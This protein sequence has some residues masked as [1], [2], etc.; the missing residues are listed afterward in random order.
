ML[1]ILFSVIGVPATRVRYMYLTKSWTTRNP[2]GSI[3]DLGVRIIKHKLSYAEWNDNKQDWDYVNVPCNC[4]I[5]Q[6]TKK[7]PV[8]LSL[9]GYR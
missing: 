9:F 2:D 3:K 6:E 5:C 8:Q 7:Q 4:E 1:Q